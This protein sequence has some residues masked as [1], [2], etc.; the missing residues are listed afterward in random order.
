MQVEVCMHLKRGM[1]LKF[2]PRHCST[3]LAQEGTCMDAHLLLP[4]PKKW[5]LSHGHVWILGADVMAHQIPMHIE[6]NLYVSGN[7]LAEHQA[8]LRSFCINSR[9]RAAREA[10]AQAGRGGSSGTTVRTPE[11]DHIIVRHPAEATVL[12]PTQWER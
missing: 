3:R 4:L 8:D 5:L 11:G 1:A 9:V 12:F 7:V 6:P 10:D 2:P